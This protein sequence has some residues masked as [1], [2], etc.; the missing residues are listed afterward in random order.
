M[1]SAMSDPELVVHLLVPNGVGGSI[2]VDASY[3]S[4]LPVVVPQLEAGDTVVTA[5]QRHLRRAWDLEPIFLETHLPPPPTPDD[6]YVGL[7]VLEA[8]PTEWSP[9]PGLRWGGAEPA[10]PE[11]IE[12]RTA[13]W[14]GEWRAAA[15]PPPLRPRWSR[16]GWHARA[17]G[18]I[19]DRLGEAGRGR[20]AEAE[21][22]RLWGISVLMRVASASGDVWFKSVFPH[23]HHEPAVTALLAGVCPEAL[24]AVIAT[25]PEE[26]W[27]LLDAA[28]APLR[29]DAH[30]DGAVLASIGLLADIQV[31]TLDLHDRL[32]SF[33][34]PAR[35]LSLLADA[36]RDALADA[37]ELGGVTV[38]TDRA[39][40][41]VAWV[42]ERALWLDRF[43]LPE[44]LL[45]GDFHPGNVLRDGG[46]LRI[47]DWS[48]AAIA[49]PVM[50][51]GPWFGEVRPDVRPAGWEAW[52]QAFERF[53]DVEKLHP[54]E[55]DA[56][57]L[58]CAYQVVSYAGILRGLEPANRYQV[59]DGFRGYWQDLNARVPD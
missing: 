12:A 30:A 26:G 46:D 57:A 7:S 17:T 13:A 15:E 19:A 42:D 34:C 29:D 39:S 20:P 2:L 37:V 6:G 51:I 40:R 36:L 22:R 47:I 10:T 52:L 33:G 49:H 56:Y 35:P 48:D 41:V 27:L 18:W 55:Q 8:P 58:S 24:P 38:A 23:F 32:R 54:H 50:E 28:G 4:R 14:L 45:H 11:R 16:P 21:M 25:E 3:A 53:G 9:P 5:L 43:G 31:A 1:L 44:V 59:T